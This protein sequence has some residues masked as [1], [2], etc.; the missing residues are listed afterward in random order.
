MAASQKTTRRPVPSKTRAKGVKKVTV[1]AKTRDRSTPVTGLR[2]QAEAQLRTT[3]RDL[4]AMSVKD[5]QQLV[6]ELQVH[7]IELEMQN[8]ELRQTQVELEA[9]REHYRDLYYDSAPIGYLTVN[10]TGMILEANLPVCTVLRRNR[11]EL[12][13]TSVIGCMAAKDQRTFRRHLREVVR[14]GSRQTCDVNFLH[15]DDAPVSIQFESVAVQEESGQQTRVLIALLDVTARTQAETALR[16]S[17]DRLR[18]ALEIAHMGTWDLDLFTHCAVRSV[19][20]DRIFGYPKLLP[21]WT[22]EIFMEHVLPED[23]EPV[24]HLFKLAVENKADWNFECRIRRADRCVRWISAIGKPIFNEMGTMQYLTGFV[25]D[26]TARKQAEE[27]RRESETRLRALNANLDHVI[28]MR[29]GELSESEVRLRTLFEQAAVG[30]A[31]IDTAT[32][33]FLRVN[34]KYSEIVGYSVEEMRA[35]DFMPITH[36]NDVTSDLAQMEQLKRGEQ[37]EFTLEKR[38]LHKDGSIIWVDLT[39]SPLWEPGEAPT[40]HM[41]VVKDITKRKQAE[42][43]LRN[44]VHEFHL[45]AD[46]VPAFYASIDRE[47]RYRY[48]NKR[49]EES[50][51]PSTSDMVGRPVKDVVG[52]HNFHTIE[53][54]LR[55]AFLGQE[56]SSTYPLALPNGDARWIHVQYV[57]D[58]DDTGRISRLLALGTDVT[59]QK[60]VELALLQS[61]LVLKEKREALQALAKKLLW[62]QDEERKRI[63][64]DLHDDFN[65]RLAALSVELQSL[66]QAPITLPESVA[67]QLAAIRE[68][69]VQLSD[70]LHNLAYKLHP[71]LLEHVGLEVTMR[72][73]LDAFMKRTGLSVTFDARKV[74]ETLSSEVATNLFRVMQESLQNVSKHAQATTVTVRLSGSSKGVGVSVRDNGKGFKH[75]TKNARIKG[76]GLVSMQERARGLGGFLRIHALPRAGTKVC[77]W[78]PHVQKGIGA[79]KK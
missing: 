69:V 45:L 8:E 38:Y 68:Q 75:E 37:H 9:A 1:M 15:G 52:E 72:D 2:Q 79:G 54:H 12:L 27:A 28:T 78:I 31:E 18:G 14:T 33:R 29:T 63:A 62:T 53:P 4:A 65:Q 64:R 13:G 10:P 24:A 49:Y 74:P 46:N 47:L 55:E 39:V 26:I 23:R 67:R 44:R 11:S 21:E 16:Q 57:P 17:D 30:V 3:R 66:E 50:F 19:E 6:Q 41:A 70:D 20:H 7:Q 56:V 77:A 71:S 25:Q 5:V 61:Q 43:A 58:R 73:H 60:Q 36:P 40:R 32:G 42:D 51:G 22:Y 76:L 48:V 59:A 34:H 35:L